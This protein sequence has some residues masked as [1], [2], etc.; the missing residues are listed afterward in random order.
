MSKI[1]FHTIVHYLHMSTPVVSYG[2][3]WYCWRWTSFSSYKILCLFDWR[4]YILILKL[5]IRSYLA[6]IYL[7]SYLIINLSKMFLLKR[8]KQVSEVTT[9]SEPV[10]ICDPCAHAHTCTC[11]YTRASHRSGNFVGIVLF[12]LIRICYECCSDNISSRIWHTIKL[13]FDCF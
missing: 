5:F 4:V 3:Y 11:I 9:R 2:L 10:T 8:R 12:S 7:I 6:H 13:R 1:L